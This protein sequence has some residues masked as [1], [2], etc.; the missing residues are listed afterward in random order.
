MDSTFEHNINLVALEN[1]EPSPTDVEPT[2]PALLLITNM[3]YNQEIKT[4]EAEIVVA[5]H[6]IRMKYNFFAIGTN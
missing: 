4:C 1:Q 2:Y 5:G 3:Y 6:Q